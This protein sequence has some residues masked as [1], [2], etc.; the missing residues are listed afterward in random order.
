VLTP[1]KS[2]RF[3][4]FAD[5]ACSLRQFRPSRGAR[6]AR[7]ST[8][9][10]SS[11]KHQSKI[12]KACRKT[13]RPVQDSNRTKRRELRSRTI[14]EVDPASLTPP[15]ITTECPL[16]K[17]L[18]LEDLPFPLHIDVHVQDLNVSLPA[19]CL[20]RHEMSL[21][22]RH[23]CESSQDA[24]EIGRP[25]T[26][27]EWIDSSPTSPRLAIAAFTLH[28]YPILPPSSAYDNNRNMILPQ[29]SELLLRY[30]LLSLT[31]DALFEA[32]FPL[33]KDRRIPTK[34]STKP[35]KTSNGEGKSALLT[36]TIDGSV[37]REVAEGSE[38]EGEV[39][40]GLEERLTELETEWRDECVQR[41]IVSLRLLLR[42]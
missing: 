17:E 15:L 31:D 28:D 34:G 25:V 1:C 12:R 8:V 3:F 11:Q 19:P 18:Q 39:M 21:A 33:S 7:K 35:K 27:D 40:K 29:R 5:L 38:Y 24:T 22:L 41:E 14:A 13:T 36:W 23:D 16:P 10:R 2:Q 9:D 30:R 42:N 6:G 37:R 20:V 32:T 4:A 26:V